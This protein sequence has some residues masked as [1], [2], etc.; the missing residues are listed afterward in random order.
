MLTEMKR[1]DIKIAFWGFT[2]AL[3]GVMCGFFG[4]QIH[5]R[6]ISVAAFCITALGILA[7][8]FGIVYGWVMIFRMRKKK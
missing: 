6:W 3:A 7:G 5:A 4:A 8:M 1:N 2:L